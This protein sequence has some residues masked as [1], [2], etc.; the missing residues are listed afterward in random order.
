M[1]GIH[2]V[3]LSA[4]LKESLVEVVKLLK[5]IKFVWK[6]FMPKAVLNALIFTSASNSPVGRFNL[7]MRTFISNQRN[8]VLVKSLRCLE[9]SKTCSEKRKYPIPVNIIFNREVPRWADYEQNTAQKYEYVLKTWPKP[10]RKVKPETTY[11]GQ[12]IRSWP[13]QNTDWAAACFWLSKTCH[14]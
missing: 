5:F 13:Y 11:R 14:A 3:G 1:E 2:S 12:L 6:N 7:A 10:S 9:R 8:T 4:K